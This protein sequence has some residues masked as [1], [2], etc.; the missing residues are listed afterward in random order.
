MLFVPI[1]IFVVGLVLLLTNLGVFTANVW[2]I[3]WPVLMM[4]FAVSLYW[5]KR[6]HGCCGKHHSHDHSEEEK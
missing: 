3:V 4:A 1:F 5:H 2:G 6:S